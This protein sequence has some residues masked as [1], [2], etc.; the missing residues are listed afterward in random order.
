MAKQRLNKEY[1]HYV[2]Q[3]GERIKSLRTEREMSQLDLAVKINIDPTALRRY[4]KGRTEMG[5][6]I[7]I[8]FAEVFE[9]SLDELIDFLDV[10]V[11]DLG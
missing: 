10:E 1:E 5:F 8:Q 9:M 7:L 3:L 4:E 11:D 6:T 2:I